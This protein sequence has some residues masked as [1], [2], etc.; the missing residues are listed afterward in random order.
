MVK[1]YLMVKKRGRRIKKILGTDDL[2]EEH[3]PKPQEPPEE[4]AVILRLKIKPEDCQGGSF[5]KTKTFCKNCAQYRHMIE[6]LQKK[7]EAYKKEKYVHGS[8]NIRF[9]YNRV[10]IVDLTGKR[11]RIKRTKI[12]C[13][14]DCHE[15][16]NLP[17]FLPELYRN[18][19]Y[20]V[21]G[22][23]CSFNCALAYNLYYLR[24]A[25]I[26]HRKSLVYKLYRQITGGKYAGDNKD[27][28]Y[29]APPKEILTSFGGPM[30][31]EEYRQNFVPIN[32]EYITYLPPIRPINIV[33]EERQNA[34]LPDGKYM[35]KRSKPMRSYFMF[36]GF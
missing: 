6:K 29:E 8:Q 36:H 14:W 11:I 21:I 24:D 34:E 13:W 1:N 30:T 27:V 5:C 26:A 33:L 19:T 16:D 7:I 9:Y 32:R 20:Y 15:F 25:K 22:C 3:V 10:N 4:P 35:L 2:P 28:I 17:A 31:I 18:N 12:R 23:F